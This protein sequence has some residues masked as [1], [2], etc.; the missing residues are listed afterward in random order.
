ML[1]EGAD[2]AAL[3]AR[4]LDRVDA[5]DEERASAL[6]APSARG[7]TTYLC[8]ADDRGWAVSLIQSNASGFGSWLVEP[9]TGINLHNRGLGFSLEAG[10]PAELA[11]GRRPPHTLVPA[12]ATR[13]GRLSAVLGTM[14]GD[15]QPQIVAQLATRLLRSGAGAVEAVIAPRVVL[16]G[17]TNRFDTWSGDTPPTVVVED[18]APTT[19][20]DELARRGH[21]VEIGPAFGSAFGHAHCIV[22]SPTGTFEAAADPRSVVGT[23]A[24]L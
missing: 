1:H 14:G 23:A 7:D 11:P 16:R 8:T 24:A 4:A 19:W 3:L 21:L 9:T 10:H 22:A 5:L 17:R 13:Q 15:A 20:S 12:M 6:P 2:G 18:G